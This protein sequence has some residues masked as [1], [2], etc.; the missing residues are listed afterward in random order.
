MFTTHNDDVGLG[1]SAKVLARICFIFGAVELM[2]HL[3]IMVSDI[4]QNYP[5]YF[6][7]DAVAF[8]PSIF[9]LLMFNQYLKADSEVRR[10]C[11]PI[12]CSS[13]IVVTGLLFF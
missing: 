8:G 5:I 13:Y 10:T 11:M 12:A 2:I 9:N 7:L 1:L 4:N 6:Y 3:S